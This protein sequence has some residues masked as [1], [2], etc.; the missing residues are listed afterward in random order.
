MELG[1]GTGELKLEGME[2]GLMEM[3]RMELGSAGIGVDGAGE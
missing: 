1:N 3:V 2:L